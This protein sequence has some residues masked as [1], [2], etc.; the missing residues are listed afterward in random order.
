MLNTKVTQLRKE[1]PG[2]KTI[3]KV[4]EYFTDHGYPRSADAIGDFERAKY[5]T[6]EDR[7]F[8]LYAAC[9]QQPV[10][11]VRDAWQSTRRA[12]A[13]RSGPFKGKRAAAKKRPTRAK[14]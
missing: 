3:Q 9:V 2:S 13:A 12:R 7:F 6:H 11:V 5:E 4:A 8:E 10:P 1:A 14:R